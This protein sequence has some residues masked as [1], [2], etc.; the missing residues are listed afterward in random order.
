M[1]RGIIKIDLE[2]LGV[3]VVMCVLRL[4]FS[5]GLLNTILIFGFS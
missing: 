3:E 2:V 1:W 5:D 4:Q